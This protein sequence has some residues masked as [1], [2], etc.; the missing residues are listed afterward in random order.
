MKQAGEEPIIKLG[1]SVSV[2]SCLIP[3]LLEK[4]GEKKKLELEINNTSIIEEKILKSQLDLAIVEGTVRSNEVVK[5]PLCQDELV[6]VV[7][8]NHPF[9][10][11]DMIK[12]EDL[13]GMTMISRED[14]SSI[15]NQ[16]AQLLNESG[17]EIY[18]KMKSTN[19]EAIK[20]I[21]KQGKELAILSRMLVEPEIQAEELK[22]LKVEDKK[23]IR[24][25]Q[26]IYHQ[27]KYIHESLAN[28]IEECKQM[29]IEL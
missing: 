28:L 3:L 6:I 19:T 15:R 8:P 16:Y 5:I 20:N 12:L 24:E 11:M 29:F 27:N 4:I 2:G 23:V 7:G 26:L 14:G 17:I 13:Q 25:I 9:Y 10:S 18:Q 1:A 22:I 21:V